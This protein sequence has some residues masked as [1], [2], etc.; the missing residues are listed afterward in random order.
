MILPIYGY[1]NTVLREKAKDIKPDYPGLKELIA[2]MFETM[3][4]AEGVGL[5]APQIG[6]AIRLIVID[7]APMAEDDKELKRFKKV[8]INAHILE[9]DGEP[10]LYN[11]GCLSLPGIREDV[12]RKPKVKMKYLDENFTPHEEVFEGISARVFQHEYDHLDGLLIP[13]RVSQIRRALIRNKLN[14]IVTGNVSVKYKM[15]FVKKK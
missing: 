12:R 5:A 10:W 11:E 7:A 2:D 15:K 4:E 3:Y 14:N 6:K 8:F 9:E 1:G 13:D